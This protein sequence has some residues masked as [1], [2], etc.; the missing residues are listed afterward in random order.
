[1]KRILYPVAV[2]LV[3]SS[4]TTIHLMGDSTM[5]E[6]DLS[7][8]KLERGWGM[9]FP[10][11]VDSTLHVINY[12]Q[13]GRSTK[14]FIDKG[15]WDMVQYALQPGDYVFIQFGHNDA[16]ADDPDYMPFRRDE[17]WLRREWAIPGTPGLRHR[18]GGLE[19]ENG[20]GN[21]STNPENHQI[22]TELR[23][24]KINR[25]ANDIPLQEIYGDKNADLLVVSWGGT[26]G[27]VRTAVEGLMEEGKS[28]AHAHFDYIMPLPRNTE[29]VLQGHKKIVVC[30][31]NRGQFAKYLRMNF[32]EYKCEQFN[33][34]MGL[35][36]TIGE[37]EAKFNDLLK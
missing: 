18:V 34:V 20:K 3:A 27:T 12:A 28:I 13:N 5:A 2:W 10:N 11:F 35:P 36:F 24:E 14:S 1:M 16:K 33:K 6:K 25:V 19:K 17:K 23:E 4:F 9:M 21:L 31:I 30:E 8:G 32:P 29:E 37:L 22:M 26:F 15:L 7:D